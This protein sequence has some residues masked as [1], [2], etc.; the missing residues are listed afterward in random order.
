MPTVLTKTACPS[1]GHDDD[2]T[3]LAVRS[4]G[5]RPSW[6]SAQI[7]AWWT[8]APVGSS[9]QVHQVDRSNTSHQS[10]SHHGRHI[11]QGHH[12]SLRR[13][14]QHPYR[15]WQQFCFQRISRLLRSVRH[16]TQLCISSSPTDQWSSGEDQWLNLPRNQEKVKQSSRRM[17]RRTPLCSVEPM[18]HTK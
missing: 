2:T 14:T 17:G 11:L 12:L 16:Q 18:H 1:Y 3:R 15:Q 5:T 13:A 6:T 8:H 9:R 7:F 10:S 4:V